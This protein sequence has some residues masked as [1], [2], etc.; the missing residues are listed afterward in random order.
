MRLSIVGGN[1]NREVSKRK[2]N[3]CCDRERTSPWVKASSREFQAQ[4]E[5]SPR[6]I[7]RGQVRKKGTHT[8][9]EETAKSFALV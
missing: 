5:A 9:K 7:G 2:N 6:Q 8:L 4:K 3:T 1:E